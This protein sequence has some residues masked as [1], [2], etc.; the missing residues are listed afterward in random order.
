MK[1]GMMTK[2]LSMMMA[3]AMFV[4]SVSWTDLGTLDAKAASNAPKVTY[5]FEEISEMANIP[6][7]N[8]TMADASKYD[9]LKTDK[10]KKQNI[11]KFELVNTDGKGKD[12][13]LETTID[14]ETGENVYPLTAKGRGNSSWTMPTGKKP[15]NIKFDKKQEI[16][17]DN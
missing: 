16:Y 17:Y 9:T 8:L 5:T 12:I 4:T 15:Y 2:L 13:Y 11:S 1:K 7:M 14:E 10:E 6:V 3:F